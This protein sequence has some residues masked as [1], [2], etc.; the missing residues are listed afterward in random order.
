MEKRID[1]KA[2]EL[3]N[4]NDMELY[5]LHL[6]A[7][8]GGGILADKLLGHTPIGACE[9]EEYPRKVLLQRQLDGI[10]P[11]F[12]IWD[13]IRSLRKDNPECSEAFKCWKGVAEKLAICG[14]FPCQDISIAGKGKGLEGNRS[15]LWFEMLR[16]IGEIRPRYVFLENS[17]R[18]TKLGATTVIAG[19]AKM[20]YVGSSGVL[21]ADDAINSSGNPAADH[22]RKRIWIVAEMA[23]SNSVWEPQQEWSIFNERRRA[24]YGSEKM[25]D[26]SSEGLQRSEQFKALYGDGDWQETYGSVTERSCVWWDEDPAEMADAE[27]I[28]AQRLDC[29]QGEGKPWRESSRPTESFVGRMAHGVANR[30]DRLKAIG[31]GQ[32]PLVAAQA[33]SYLTKTTKRRINNEQ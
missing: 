12:P 25:A 33:W 7:G 11:I 14:G 18:L 16:I 29:R 4:T 22:Q 5:T 24:V 20:G 28:Y 3:R 21:G 13:D 19:L 26:S 17:P 32:V 31:N 9:I 30:V 8:A 10:L 1:A 15:G 27:G 23:D 6:F 2:L